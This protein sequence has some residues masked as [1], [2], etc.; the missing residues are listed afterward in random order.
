MDAVL[1][2]YL[3]ICVKSSQPM[4][5][6]ALSQQ[7]E[8]Y[9]TSTALEP[10]QFTWLRLLRCNLNWTDIETI[11]GQKEFQQQ[12]KEPAVGGRDVGKQIRN[13]MEHGEATTIQKFS[14]KPE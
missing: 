1:A 8:G 7:T 6:N 14:Y 11:Y 12:Y 9:R 4:P 2:K 10:S 3:Q 13:E 5:Y